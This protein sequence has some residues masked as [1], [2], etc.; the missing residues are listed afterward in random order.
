ME[1]TMI[2]R[3]RKQWFLFVLVAGSAFPLSAMDAKRVEEECIQLYNGSELAMQQGNYAAAKLCYNTI[4]DKKND[5][6]T[7]ELIEVLKKAI[8]L[9]ELDI[10]RDE[11]LKGA[12]AALQSGN[13]AVTKLCYK[14]AYQISNNQK[15][16]EQLASFLARP[17]LADIHL[18]TEMQP[19]LYK[20]L[21]DGGVSAF[22]HRNVAVGKLC[23]M[24]ILKYTSDNELKGRVNVLL[25]TIKAVEAAKQHDQLTKAGIAAFEL[26][27]TVA[28]KLY[29]K[30]VLDHTDRSDIRKQIALVL[31]RVESRDGNRELALSLAFALYRTTHSTDTII[32]DKALAFYQDLT[33]EIGGSV[34]K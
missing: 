2:K 6:E 30:F 16:K 32:K 15:I 27:N 9:A 12:T 34:I 19:D 11:L 7:K 28:A 21:L 18:D 3:F 31:A 4:S 17:E 24:H 23:F 14:H 10:K 33:E 25:N 13:K 22:D 1:N 5:K 8:T 20:K 29:L 26:G